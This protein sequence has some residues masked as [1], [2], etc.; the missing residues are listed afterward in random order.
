[1]TETS[2]GWGLPL[3]ANNL[4]TNRVQ[5]RTKATRLHVDIWP[6][7][8][9]NLR[10]DI[11][12]AAEELPR[13]M[14]HEYID[15]LRNLTTDQPR[16]RSFVCVSFGKHQSRIP[17]RDIRFS[18]F[19]DA[20]QLQFKARQLPCTQDLLLLGTGLSDAQISQHRL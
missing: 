5:S 13:Y 8:L 3:K 4:L 16:Q 15:T 17:V 14:Q 18:K 2:K 19:L 9:R 20:N 10:V 6:C 11:I 1:M 7:C 12:L